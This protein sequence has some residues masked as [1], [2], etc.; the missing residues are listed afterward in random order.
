MKATIV[1]TRYGSRNVKMSENPIHDRE[2]PHQ[3]GFS[4]SN[5]DRTDMHIGI[6][7][8][9]HANHHASILISKTFPRRPSLVL[10]AHQNITLILLFNDRNYVHIGIV[11]N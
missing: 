5:T 9:N 1:F 4:R 10:H 6:E 3:V 8:G 7:R 2:Q 11:L